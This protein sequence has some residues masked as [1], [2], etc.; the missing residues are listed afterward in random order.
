MSLD[1]VKLIE[2]NPIQRFTGNVQS[3]LVEKIKSG[4]TD[5]QHKLFLSSFYCYF[6]CEKTD[7]VIDLDNIW[8]WM[9]FNQKANAKRIIEKNFEIDKDYKMSVVI[10]DNKDVPHGGSN[11]QTILLTVPAFKRFCLKAGTTKAYEI[12]EYYIKLEEILQDVLCEES[13][14][15]KLKFEN[16]KLETDNANKEIATLKDNRESLL[17]K[18]KTLQRQQLMLSEFS[19]TCSLVYVI[20]VKTF[21]NGEYIV[22]IGESRCGITERYNAHKTSYGDIL[23]LDV[24]R[25]EDSKGLESFIHNHKLIKLNKVTDM[26]GH[27]NEMELFLIGKNLSYTILTNLIRHNVKYY[28]DSSSII[29]KCMLENDN[30]K[31]QLEICKQVTNVNTNELTMRLTNIETAQSNMAITMVKI[32]EQLNA[33]NTKTTTGFNDPLVTLGPRLQ[34]INP[35]TLLLVKIYE[36]VSECMKE[37][38]AIKRPS[39]NK[40]VVENTVYNGFRWMLVDRQLDANIIH[41]ISPTRQTKARNVGYIAQLSRDKSEIVNVFIDRKSAA[42]SNGYESSSALDNPVKSFKMANGFYYKLYDDCDDNVKTSFVEKN[43]GEPLLY[44]NGVGQY[45]EKNNLVRE[46]VCKYDVIKGMIMS[47]KT[48]AKALE[49][50]IQYNGFSYRLLGSKTKCL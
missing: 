49:K 28:N 6:N 37:D 21:E 10:K 45:D 16:A 11:K 9:G 20:R 1:I 3:K 35:E 14:E 41:N 19:K 4:F 40:A 12:H 43:N 29:R 31:V 25:V 38:T 30:L 50:E 47:D 26:E 33:N 23:L 22:K 27:E 42:I 15:L 13:A 34:K 24:F 8:T 48:L 39:V 2:S 17:T 32:L 18:E 5:T 44:K 7:F 36:T 46:F